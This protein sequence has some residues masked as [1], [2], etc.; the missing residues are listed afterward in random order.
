VIHK[1][2]FQYLSPTK[3]FRDYPITTVC[4]ESIRKETDEREREQRRTIGWMETK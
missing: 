2:K 3:S 4:E 1:G